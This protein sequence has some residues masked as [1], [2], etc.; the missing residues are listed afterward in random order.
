MQYLFNREKEE[1]IIVSALEHVITG[2]AELLQYGTSL[3][4]GITDEQPIMLPLPETCQVCNVD[5]CLGCNL[6]LPTEG[7][8]GT[9][10]R[11]NRN[12]KSP[13]RGV[14]QRPWGK[15]AAEIRDPWKAERKWL[16]TFSTAEAAARAYDRQNVM[17]R[18]EK[19]KLNFPLSEYKNEIKIYEK[20]TI[21][22]EKAKEA[23]GTNNFEGGGTSAL[24]DHNYKE[25]SMVEQ[26]QREE[27]HPRSDED[28]F[29]F[30]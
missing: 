11:R 9:N 28:I 13:Y 26:E 30:C 23:M 29:A 27:Q 24:R 12:K 1:A 7:D 4:S 18:G 5:G 17:F 8:N 21:E 2:Q 10:I 14:R 3:P 25:Q 20:K 16:G 19:A 6:F 22:N 15:W